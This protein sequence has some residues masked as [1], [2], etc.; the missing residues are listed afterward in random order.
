LQTV[1]F[2]Q[3]TT[4]TGRTN[5][6]NIVIGRSMKQPGLGHVT[7]QSQLLLQFQSISKRNK[8]LLSS[9][10]IITVI[11]VLSGAVAQFSILLGELLSSSTTLQFHVI[12][13]VAIFAEINV[14]CDFYVY[15]WRSE[16]YRTEFKK[17]LKLD[18]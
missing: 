3:A 17:L 18:P 13:D 11:Y 8:H 15:C 1:G 2:G 6:R 5:R 9:F 12:N 10:L 14:V 7:G 16:E 4:E